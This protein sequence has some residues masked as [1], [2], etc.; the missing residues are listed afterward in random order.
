MKK[1]IILTLLSLSV[2]SIVY[3]QEYDLLWKREVDGYMLMQ[4]Q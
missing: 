1:V 3:A 4:W 2:F